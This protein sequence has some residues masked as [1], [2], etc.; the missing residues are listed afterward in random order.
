ML[1]TLPR[2]TC[3]A[4]PVLGFAAGVTFPLLVVPG[5]PAL[6]PPADEPF[7][8][9]VTSFVVAAF[10]FAYQ[11]VL[12]SFHDSPLIRRRFVHGDRVVMAYLAM[13][14]A[15]VGILWIAVALA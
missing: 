11:S 12:L 2:S 1:S 10:G 6:A 9:A 3:L 14:A 4:I 8:V 5:L 7:H 13:V 15:V